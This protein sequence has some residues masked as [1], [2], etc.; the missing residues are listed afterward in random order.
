MP[1]HFELAGI[2]FEFAKHRLNDTT[3]GCLSI[4]RARPASRQGGST[5]RRGD[6]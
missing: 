3:L 1:A 4:S 6:G 2:L 5:L